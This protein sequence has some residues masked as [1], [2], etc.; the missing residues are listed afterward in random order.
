[1]AESA[2]VKQELF[3]KDGK[4]LSLDGVVSVDGLSDDYLTVNTV[5]GSIS[6]EGEGLRIDS[7]TK[8]DGRIK[9]IGRIRGIFY[10]DKQEKEGIFK[11]LFG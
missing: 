3:V 1:M 2:E 7:L 11:K 4:S 6:I 5:S 8:E 10:K 9:V